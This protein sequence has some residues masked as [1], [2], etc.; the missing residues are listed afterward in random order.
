MPVVNR[1][2]R[3][4]A[5]AARNANGS[6]TVPHFK[7]AEEVDLTLDVTA[8]SG[9][10]PT[11]NVSVDYVDPASG[12]T[13]NVGS[14]TQVGAATGTETISLTAIPEEAVISWTLGGVTPNYTFSI[15]ARIK[16]VV[17]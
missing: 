1:L 10:T 14:F 4:L 16:D 3:I 8:Q 13:V 17:Q 2:G 6:I 15:G 9:T 5:S 11:L 7:H 12:K